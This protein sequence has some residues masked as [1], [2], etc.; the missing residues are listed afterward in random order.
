MSISNQIKTILL[1]GLLT[2]L[3]LW[4]GNL[5]GGA[6]GL[7]FALIFSILINF[8]T[9]WFSDKIALAIYKAKP[10]KES[11][12]QELY[13]IVREISKS[14]K[15]PMP[16]VFLID[17]PYAN[18]FATGRNPKHSAVAVTKGIMQILDKEELKGVIA[19]EISHIK[20]RDT[21]IA[22]IAATIAAIISYLAVIVRYL[23]IGGNGRDKGPS[24]LEWIVL[25]FL[26][27]FLAM[28]IQLAISRSREY[29]ADASGA[30]LAHSGK[31]LADALAKL[32]KQKSV[33]SLRRSS[34]TQTSAHMFI[35]N[36]FKGEAFLHMFMTHPSTSERIK[37]LRE[38]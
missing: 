19:H 2:A 4:I 34:T 15:I 6:N 9:Y 21:L 32:E 16:R 17:A 12:Q 24:L 35:T 37:R 13:K 25:G 5:V 33:A 1:L 26:T 28:L 3:L 22:T 30:K 7:A 8:G 38:I 10:V 27:P 31:G 23:P 14:A 11:D 29:I 20:N 18:A 36:P